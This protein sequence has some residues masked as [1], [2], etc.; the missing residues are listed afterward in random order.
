MIA[1]TY[2]A[3][4]VLAIAVIMMTLRNVHPDL[5]DYG[6]KF[7]APPAPIAIVRGV[8]ACDPTSIAMLGVIMILMIP[9]ARTL[10]AAYIFIREKDR[11]FAVLS[12]A[13][14]ITLLV[15]AWSH[16][17]GRAPDHADHAPGDTT[18]P[19]M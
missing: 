19:S 3:M 10:G 9:A 1:G 7:H 16:L 18:V 4:S 2:A 14:V 17:A 6:A 8:I 13:I 12:L 15:G 5:H 11:L